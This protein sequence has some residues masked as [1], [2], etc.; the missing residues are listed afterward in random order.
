MNPFIQKSGT[1]LLM[2]PRILLVN[3]QLVFPRLWDQVLVLQLKGRIRIK[4]YSTPATWGDSQCPTNSCKYP[5]NLVLTLC[6][7][8]VMLVKAFLRISTGER[9]TFS[10]N[11]QTLPKR[12][13]STATM[14]V[15]PSIWPWNLMVIPVQAEPMVYCY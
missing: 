13:T 15:I 6:T 12:T 7:V 9:S 4:R 5:P 11:V 3:T 14:A 2:I 8:W 1:V 10:P